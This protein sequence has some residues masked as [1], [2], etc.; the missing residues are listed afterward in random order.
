MPLMT[1]IPV[2]ASSNP[3]LPSNASYGYYNGSK[4]LT[5]ETYYFDKSYTLTQAALTAASGQEV[6]MY[7]NGD[8]HL[9][10]SSIIGNHITIVATGSVTLDNN[11]FINVFNSTDTSNLKIYAKEIHLTTNAYIKGDDVSL[12]SKTTITLDNTNAVNATNSSNSG[13][14]KLYANGII[15][16][17]NNA[18]VNGD[19]VEIQT[20]S[21]NKEAILLDNTSSINKEVDSAIT[22]IYSNGGL[23]LT[24]QVK[25]GGKAGQVIA[26]N[27]IS[28]D[29][30]VQ[31][32]NTV[33]ISN[34]SS[35]QFYITGN[36]EISAIYTKGSIKIDGAP[37]INHKEAV[38]NELALSG[39]A[40][41]QTK[42]S[43]E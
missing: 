43:H 16:L 25:I 27:N 13:K 2:S 4:P 14:M 32:P 19:L 42:W 21:T 39:T 41:L 31:A 18:I 35:S 1:E 38:I 15:H 11:S 8:L 33:F 3:T 24:N 37:I 7:I 30:Q 9:T 40:G 17:T 22:K 23:H 5:G 28:I 26:N 29:N 36:T 10:N 6:T 34:S 20:S 12:Q